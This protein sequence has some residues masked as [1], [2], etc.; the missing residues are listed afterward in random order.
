MHLLKREAQLLRR[1]LLPIKEEILLGP[2]P[3]KDHPWWDGKQKPK[4]PIATLID[5]KSRRVNHSPLEM[6][7]WGFSANKAFK[8]TRNYQFSLGNT[9]KVHKFLKSF[10]ILWDFTGYLLRNTSCIPGK[11]LL[12][13]R[14][15]KLLSS[16]E[17]KPSKRT[18]RMWYEYRTRFILRAH[19][20]H[21]SKLGV[22]E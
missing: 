15:L 18:S 14:Y 4:R 21:Y 9:K 16:L 7:K 5:L 6:E 19:T 3:P 11:Y 13:P 8:G 2:V 22:I 17:D 12:I 20:R 1:P 10:K